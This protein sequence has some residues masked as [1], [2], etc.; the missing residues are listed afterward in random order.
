MYAGCPIS[1]YSKLQTD[2]AHSSTE[3]E[4]IDP[5]HSLKEV[6]QKILK[7]TLLYLQF[8]A[9]FLKITLEPLKLPGSRKWNQELN[10]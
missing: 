2:I 8:I 6:K 4:Y 9:K 5:L 10:I 7:L 1:W 3:D